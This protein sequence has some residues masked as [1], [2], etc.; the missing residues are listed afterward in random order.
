LLANA[1]PHLRDVIVTALA[2]A[3]RIGEIL[4][5]QW[6]QVRFLQNEIYLPGGKTKS[7]RDRIVPI[8]IKPELHEIL[9]RRQ[10][11]TVE[12]P[13]GRQTFKFGPEHYVF[14]DE[15]GRQIKNIKTA[16]ANCVLKAHG[17]EPER[18]RRGGSLTAAC[19]RRLAEIDLHIHD[20][21]HECASRL[22]FDQGWTIY[23]VSIL[24]GHADVKTTERYLGVADKKKRLHDLVARPMLKAVR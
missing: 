6:K 5:L 20:L 22:Y 9:K 14:G 17:V 19:L 8:T 4:S 21:R 24:L 13:H 11:G 7:K 23:D 15:A 1:N 3:M 2:G 10:E 16:W 18:A 12:G